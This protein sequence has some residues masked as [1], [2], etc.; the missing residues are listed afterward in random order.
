MKKLT[1]VTLAFT[2][3]FIIVMSSSF[4]NASLNINIDVAKSNINP[5]EDQQITATV[6]EKGFGIILIIQPA[7]GPAWTDYLK[8]DLELK[9]LWVIIPDE[10]KQQVQAAIGNKIVSY[11]LVSF[12]SDGGS[13]TFDFVTDFTGLNGQ[14]STG[15]LGEYKV[16]FVYHSFQPWY[17]M[18]TDFACG[19][20]NVVP[21]VPLGTAVAACSMI[22]AVGFVKYKKRTPKI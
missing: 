2:A 22:A 16:V 19:S 5:Y 21:E 7:Q 4:A 11:A 15:L 8:N 14:P 6:N 3:V 20:W 9:A 12:S 10:I 13:E 18:E 17:F 1:V